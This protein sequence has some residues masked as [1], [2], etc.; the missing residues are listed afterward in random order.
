MMKKNSSLHLAYYEHDTAFM[1]NLKQDKKTMWI[2]AKNSDKDKTNMDMLIHTS[3]YN[4]VPVE[5]LDCCFG[6]N[7][8]SGQQERTVCINHFDARSYDSHTDI[9]VGARIATSNVNILP[10]VGLYNGPI[11]SVVEIIYQGKPVGPNNI[12]HNHLPDYV[13]A[14]FPNLNLP[15]GIPTSD[16]LHKMVSSTCWLLLY[17]LGN[18]WK[19]RNFQN[20]DHM[21]RPKFNK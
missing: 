2:Y 1:T 3:K 17:H 11:G 14:D 16:E 4:R 9:C 20:N 7:W 18:F 6:T 13:V 19:R 12:E 21:K 10:E 8:L 5:W 15:T